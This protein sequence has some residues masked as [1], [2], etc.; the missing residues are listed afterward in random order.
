MQVS[1]LGLRST[2]KL[3]DKPR[4]VVDNQRELEQSHGSHGYL[5]QTVTP[6]EGLLPGSSGGL[7][8]DSL[9]L[10]PAI[11]SIYHQISQ[12]LPVDRFHTLHP[13]MLRASAALG[14]VVDRQPKG[15]LWPPHLQQ[16]FASMMM[17][18]EAVNGMTGPGSG[19]G[20]G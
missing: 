16:L 4:V 17:M 11:H 9:G 13:A 2:G 15:Q 1:V 12:V 5:R 8:G 7:S 19:S 20:S 3:P 6:S 14:E 18:E 10:G